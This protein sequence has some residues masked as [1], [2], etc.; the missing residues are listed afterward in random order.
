[1]AR[2]ALVPIA[3][4]VVALAAASRGGDDSPAGPSGGGGG[5]SDGP[6]AATITIT[7][8]GISPSTVTVAPGSRVTFQNTDTR[9]HEPA[10][11]PHRTHGSCPEIEQIGHIAAGQSQT[12]AT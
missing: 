6:V 10:S 2:T 4:A 1:M 5:G 12:T 11:D 9:G 8:S 3:L 7:A